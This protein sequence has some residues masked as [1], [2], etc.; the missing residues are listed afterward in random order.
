MLSENIFPASPEK[1]SCVAVAIPWKLAKLGEAQETSEVGWICP[2]QL[3]A[4][5]HRLGDGIRKLE[6]FKSVQKFNSQEE[7]ES[8]NKSES[9]G[10]VKKSN[11]LRWEIELGVHSIRSQ[12]SDCSAQER[13]RDQPRNWALSSAF[14]TFWQRFCL[15]SGA[16]EVF[17]HER[18]L[19]LGN[20]TLQVCWL[21]APPGPSLW[22]ENGWPPFW[23]SDSWPT[24]L[25]AHLDFHVLSYPCGAHKDRTQLGNRFFFDGIKTIY[26][27]AK[28]KRLDQII[29]PTLL[30]AIENLVNPSM[31]GTTKSMTLYYRRISC[32][33][34]IPHMGQ[35]T[36]ALG[37]L[38]SQ[39][40]KGGFFVAMQL[41]TSAISCLHFL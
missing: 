11:S 1:V 18:Q 29:V 35:F 14:W 4:F 25:S 15:K 41:E 3:F 23:S 7:L 5:G 40:P 19:S 39:V 13:P 24:T 26:L 12:V 28:L 6:I 16:R 32:G 21:S 37:K 9:K 27:G 38:Y 34:L 17:D 20:S 2:Y 30:E 31:H 22:T 10:L 33:Y 8:L 36:E